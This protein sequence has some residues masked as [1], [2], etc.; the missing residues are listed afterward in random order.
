M[1]RN[2]RNKRRIR[3]E[4]KLEYEGIKNNRQRRMI[5][6]GQYLNRDRDLIVLD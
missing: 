4:R 3:Q 6:N 2:C 1:I 5:E